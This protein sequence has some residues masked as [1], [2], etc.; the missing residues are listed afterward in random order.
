MS[1]PNES[2]PNRVLNQ[3]KNGSNECEASGCN[4]KATATIAV[5]VGEKRL[6]YVSVCQN[7]T[8][9]FLDRTIKRRYE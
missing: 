3:A 2:L 6:I 9:I 5:P 8:D 1:C 4:A 7:C